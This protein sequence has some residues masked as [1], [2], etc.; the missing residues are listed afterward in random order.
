MAGEIE[1]SDGSKVTFGALPNDGQAPL[2][3]TFSSKTVTWFKV[4]VT[5]ASPTT[6]NIGFS[7]IAAYDTSAQ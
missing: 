1:F 6:E 5:A 2:L 4:T 7:E 3:V